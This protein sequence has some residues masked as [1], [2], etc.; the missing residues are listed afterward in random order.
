MSVRVG[1][2][3]EH[4]ST[5]IKF[6]QS[7]KFFQ[8]NG[9]PEIELV[10]YPSGS[11]HLITSLNSGEID[12]AVGLTEAFV[13]GLAN[14]G[15]SENYEIIGSYVD[16][17]LCWSI[18][19]GINRT[20]INSVDDLQNGKKIGVSRIGS[21]SYVM[22]YVLGIQEKFSKPF[23]KDFIVLDNFQNL[24][25]SVNL[26]EGIEGSDAFMWEYFTSKKY[27]DNKEIKKIGEIYTPWSSWV[28]IIRKDLA[29]KNE[30]AS[31]FLKSVQQGIS[32]FNANKEE[33][34]EYI[35][36]NLDYSK[37]DAV[38]W[39]KTVK[40]SD[41]VT[42]IDFKKNIENTVDILKTANVITNDNAIDNL[43]RFVRME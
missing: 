40:F 24:R 12:I 22:S 9:L 38:N 42:K 28:I 8:S 27:Y 21:G 35:Y 13:R 30:I 33:S 11:G 17:P 31:N 39:L 14:N 15:D 1:I 20:D 37:E 2:I 26:V 36:N 5:P 6:S 43:K 23:F 32:Y 7:K 34:V 4:F 25:K 41:D 3:P 18:S 10:D 16:S 19:T 29:N